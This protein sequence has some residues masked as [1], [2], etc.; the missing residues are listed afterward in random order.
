[1][2]MLERTLKL[3]WKES[4]HFLIG[5]L[6]KHDSTKKISVY[7]FGTQEVDGSECD[8]QSHSF[9]PCFS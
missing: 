1:M 2:T 5:K 7:L 9:S 8:D 4:L 6:S 3:G